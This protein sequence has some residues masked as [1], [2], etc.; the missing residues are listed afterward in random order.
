MATSV[1]I[2]QIV[3]IVTPPV[4]G[5]DNYT[6]ESTYSEATPLGGDWDNAFFLIKIV[7]PGTPAE[8]VYQNVCALSDVVKYKAD[9]GLAVDDEDEYYRIEAWTLSFESL[10]EANEEVTLQKLKTQYLCDDWE[11]YGGSSYPDTHTTTI[12]SA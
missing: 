3:D 10:E 12:T 8:D 9:R 11:E 4:P 7:T 5:E 2:V 6:L 1:K